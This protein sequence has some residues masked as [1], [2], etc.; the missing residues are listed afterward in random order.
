MKI[1]ST[2]GFTLIETLIAIAIFAIVAGGTYFA[3][4]NVLDIT[5]AAQLNS[6]GLTVIANELEVIRNIQYADVGTQGGSPTGILLAEKNI[7]FSGFNFFLKTT[8]RNIDDPFDGTLGGSP[9]D[10]APADYKLVELELTCLNCGRFI[11]ITSTTRVAP[12]NLESSS[13][14]GNIFI[15]VLDASGDPISQVDVKVINTAVNPTININDVTNN[16]GQLQ[17]VDIAT[18]SLAYEIAVSKSGYSLDQTYQPG[19]PTNPNPVKPHATVVSQQLTEIYFS[20][21]R[22]ST[23]NLTTQDKFC[24]AVPNINFNQQGSKLIGT[25][26]DIL[27]YSVSDETDTNGVK[28]NANVE[29][30]NYTLTNTDPNYSLAGTSLLS[31]F[32][33]NPNMNYSVK[34]LVE[35][36]NNSSFLVVVQDGSGQ[37]INEASVSLTKAGFNETKTSGHNNF[38]QTDW[39]GG[40]FT[41]KS[42]N[43]EET[44]V[45]EI[46]IKQIGGKYA[47][48]SLEWLESRTFNLGA[49]ASFH[50]LIWNPV[51]QPSQ[52]GPDSLKF[53][54]AANNDNVTWNFIGPDGTIGTYYTNSDSLI[55]N[56]HNGNQYFR[57]KAY[58]T[59]EDEDFTPKLEDVAFNFSSSCLPSGQSFYSG[60]TMDT[61]SLTVKKPGFQDYVAPINIIGGWQEH[62]VTLVP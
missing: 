62:R 26:P 30:D 44:T 16:S 3:Y 37:F 19:A 48:T 32:N 35:P 20:I 11:P 8:V 12:A 40:Q 43:I 34:W 29:W 45:G 51:N 38:S 24:Q 13:K 58:L 46:K 14:N 52:S 22:L 7:N 15:H 18:S 49:P 25:D 28:I 56:G 21:D 4:L 10:T 47:S 59:T 53:Q 61:Y 2:K 27:K 5:I 55:F 50:R 6:T 54:I 33:V 17:L 9:N 1:F 39:S 23:Q 42:Q 60:L 41:Q 57:Y 36:Q 31:P